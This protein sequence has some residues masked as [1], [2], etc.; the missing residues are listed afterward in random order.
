MQE[1]QSPDTDMTALFPWRYAELVTGRAE[2]RYRQYTNDLD[3]LT[4]FQVR[5]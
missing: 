4:Q 5:C 3:T 2:R 1:F